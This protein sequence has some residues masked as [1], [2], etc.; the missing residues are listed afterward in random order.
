MSWYKSN[1]NSNSNNVESD[2]S[3]P[4]RE[5]VVQVPQSS[6]ILINSSPQSQDN[7]SSIV[8]QPSIN[9][10]QAD[11]ERK[12]QILRS[13]PNYAIIKS[14]FHYLNESDILRALAKFKGNLKDISEFLN[15]NFPADKYNKQPEAPPVIHRTPTIEL[16]SEDESPVKLK[17]RAKIKIEDSPMKESISHGQ[18][19][20]STKVEVR[21]TQSL[22]NKYKQQQ[23]QPS[24][25]TATRGRLDSLINPNKKRR[26]VRASDSLNNISRS[27]SSSPVPAPTSLSEKFNFKEFTPS[28]STI[29]LSPDDELENLERKIAENRKKAKLQKNN[30]TTIVL[31]D[32]DEDDDDDI[33]DAS[34]DDHESGHQGLTSMDNKILEFVNNASLDDIID[35][36]GIEPTFAEKV[37]EK[38][39]F[40][41]IYEISD[42]NFDEPLNKRK[43]T[44]GLKMI[45][46]IESSLRGY[47][48]IDS[49]IKKCSEFGDIVNRQMKLWGVSK[50]EENGELDVLELNPED[51][52][53]EEEEEEEEEDDDDNVIIVKKQK[54]L[55]YIKEKPPLLADDITLNNYQQVGIN[56][57]NCLYHNKLSCIL[58]DEMGL[59]KTCQVIAFMAYLKHTGEPYPHLVVVP[60]S[61]LENWLREFQKFCPDIRVQA[62]YG[63]QKEREEL[64]YELQDADY[65][66]LV[67]TYSLACGA[68]SDVKFL[69][70]QNFNC[71]VYDEGHLLKNSQSERY[72][73]LMRLKGKFRLL[74]TGTPLQNNLK[75]LISLLA[76][77]MPHV[78]VEK[79]EDLQGIFNQKSGSVNKE[80]KSDF[81]PLISQQAIKNAKTMMTP[82]VLRR[83]KDQVLQH[84]PKKTHQ[85]VYC[86]S[87]ETQTENYHEFIK[88][89]KEVRDERERRKLLPVQEQNRLS[90][91]DPIQ[92]SSNLLMQ[93]R[94]ICLHP[95]LFRFRYDDN[96]IKKMAKAIMNEPE[97]VEAN[98]QYIFED[99]QVM[100]DLELY[101]LCVKFPFTLKNFQISDEFFLDS[102][103]ILQL[104]EILDVI[105]NQR[106][107]KV[108]I[109]SLFTQVLNILEKVLSI[110]NYKFVRLDGA[111]KVEERQD[112]IDT[113]NENP[114]I[115]IFLLSTKAGGFGINLVA[116][117]N[118][119][120]F[121]QS[122]NPH[123]DKQAEDRAHR[124]GQVKEVN[125]YKL[126]TKDTIEENML[127]IAENK[128]Q[129]DYTISNESQKDDSKFEEKQASLFEK[130]LFDEL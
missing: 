119:I 49:I 117:N 8:N 4:R 62:Y 48:A 64:R 17:G 113:F 99:M 104:K 28:S 92:S 13:H 90:K 50:N 70:N 81:N 57:I 123:D 10:K 84:L 22:V 106:G 14:K 94:K 103:K 126:I 38:R 43:K 58:A 82:F 15:N 33:S 91:E 108:L 53:E 59:G 97:Y 27:T 69:K 128:L 72:N 127:S 19:G 85:I 89:A 74:L 75:E 3:T 5:N 105:I 16:D 37:L 32:E 2:R 79:R 95:L 1:Q 41:T 120:V 67:T 100:S 56:W 26:L 34:E 76:F 46:T 18:N 115:P 116:A 101:N 63:A 80:E 86:Q 20:F 29:N 124:V 40:E 47:K 112:T 66:V 51:K 68:P 130:I 24:T 31:S 125:V 60:A 129:L 83:R 111:T 23:Q 30:Q 55:R 61:T 65:E 12:R 77:I 71:I 102:G 78:F 44:M 21:K 6:P 54:G 39:P 109:F 35:I 45:E 98:Q 88:N 87:T 36:S 110:F 11:I 118:V 96:T 25:S 42:Y 93:L 114:T 121:D 9:D 122:F 52:T 7:G 73:K 107:E